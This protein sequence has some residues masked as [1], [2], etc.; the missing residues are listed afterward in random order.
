[1]DGRDALYLAL[2]GLVGVVAWKAYEAFARNS[3]PSD[4]GRNAAGAVVDATQGAVAGT[5]SSVFGTAATDPGQC[6]CAVIEKRSFDVTKYCDAPT[7]IG[8]LFNKSPVTLRRSPQGNAVA[9]WQ[10]FRG[11]PAITA[12]YNATD[13]KWLPIKPIPIPNGWQSWPIITPVRQP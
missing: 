3:N 5:I 1:M 12:A 13:Q 7:A 6:T 8:Y 4:A 11:G 10:D 2:T 9:I